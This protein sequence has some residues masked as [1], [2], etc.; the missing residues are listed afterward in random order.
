M[1]PHDD[2]GFE[3]IHSY[4]VEQAVEDGTLID[5]GVGAATGERAKPL[6]EIV[7]MDEYLRSFGKTLGRKAITELSPLHVPGRDSLPDFDDMLREPFE[8]QKHVV[9]ATI[10]MMDNVGNGFIVGE[11]GTGKTLLGM[12]SVFKHAQR[13]R[14]QG[15]FG[16]KFRCV[17]LC[18][19]H[20]ISKWTRE[21]EETI[22][23]AVAHRFDKWT[24]VVTLL[25]HKNGSRWAKPRGPDFYVL[26]RNQA[27][28][29]PDWLGLSDP[30]CGF[31][32]ET[33][34]TSVSSKSVVVDR[35]PKLDEHDRP[36]LDGRGNPV[37]T[38]VT[39]RV[40][41]CPRCGTIARDKRGAP[42]G[43]KH[44]SATQQTCQGRYLEQIR[45]PERKQNGRDILCP[46]PGPHRD[47][48]PGQEITHGGHKWVVRECKEPLWNGTS[49]PYR[50]R[51]IAP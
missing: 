20:L 43:A 25:D 10:Q 35:V 7:S 4:S 8:P 42:L 38:S 19:D 22:P 31:N 28:W 16:G 41:Y 9:A 11:M 15:G 37:M 50:C 23:G 6:E 21:I 14:N 36:V 34:K 40:H 27:K 3:T 18:P 49:R 48:P 39:A 24:E 2:D 32:G 29:Y 17:V 1:N 44:L 12:T 13:S 47:R 51:A 45:D 26:G 46:I 30:R 33:R 5:F